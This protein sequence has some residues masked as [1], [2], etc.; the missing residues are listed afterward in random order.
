MADIDDSKYDICRV[1]VSPHPLMTTYGTST[2]PSPIPTTRISVTP[3]APSA[4]NA[5]VTNGTFMTVHFTFAN[6]GGGKMRSAWKMGGKSGGIESARQQNEGGRRGLAYRVGLQSGCARVKKRS[7]VSSPWPL[8][9][10]EE[11]L[12][13]ASSK[14]RYAFRKD[15]DTSS[16][17]TEK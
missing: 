14:V 3:A 2:P 17:P 16:R 9:C 8:L 5:N 7:V 6:M 10:L 4:C 1:L 11:L 13:A 15:S 12:D